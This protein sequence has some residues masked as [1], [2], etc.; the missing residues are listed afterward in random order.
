MYTN[1]KEGTP[2]A[3]VQKGDKLVLIAYGPP[4]ENALPIPEKPAAA[5][6]PAVPPPDTRVTAE[7]RTQMVG[8]MPS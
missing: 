4:E 7:P 5:V 1:P 3:I 2:G 8:G 6:K